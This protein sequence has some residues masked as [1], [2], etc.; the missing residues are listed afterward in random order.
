MC[1]NPE[2]PTPPS[3]NG[4]RSFLRLAGIGIGAAA[5]SGIVSVKPAHAA[6]VAAPP[7]PQNAITPDQALER[8]IAGNTR[9]IQG[10][11]Q[12]QNFLPE[13]AAL[14]EGQNPFA[15]VL[16]CADSRI[17]PEYAFDTGRGDLFAVRVAGNFMTTDG[18]A[19]LEYAVA[20]LG[21]PLLVVLG[22]ERCG[23]VAAGVKSVKEN[24]VFPGQI[25]SL[26]TALEPSVRKVL[27][28][29]GDLLENAIT[30]NVMDTAANLLKS[31][32][33][34]KEA[35]EQKRLKIVGGVYRLD[36]GEVRFI[37]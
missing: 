25:Q 18:L 31:S 17:A 1:S 24:A 19:S 27:E 14:V 5:L 22:H 7:K 10:V 26:A 9:Y 16:S 11:T 6:P 33:L 28:K 15:A 20:V 21:T 35:V 34:L 29:P 2:S 4:R 23:A 36:S 8:L 30:Q 37:V 12:R 32:D 3:F 13:R